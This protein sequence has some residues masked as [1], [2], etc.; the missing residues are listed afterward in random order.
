[1]KYFDDNWDPIK[2][3]WVDAFINEN[4]LNF[5]NNRT[6]ALN[7]NLKSVIRK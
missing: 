2:D 4:F 7:R 1:M 6:E 3:E 5:I